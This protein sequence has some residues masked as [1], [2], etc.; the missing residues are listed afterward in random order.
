MEIFLKMKKT[1]KKR[2]ALAGAVLTLSTLSAMSAFA[3]GWNRTGDS[4]EYLDKDNIPVTSEF[5]K[6]G[7]NWF[8][9]GED[10]KMITNALVENKEN[11]YFVNE[12]GTMITNEWRKVDTDGEEK[13]R[14]YYFD[15]TGKALKNTSSSLSNSKLKTINGKKYA[16]DSEGRM[17]YGWVSKDNVTVSDD[18]MAY[19]DADYYFGVEDDGAAATGWKQITVEKDG[20][21]KNAW[22]YFDDFGRKKTGEKTINGKKYVFD[23]D[24]VMKEDWAIKAIATPS[25]TSRYYLNGDGAKRVKTWFYAVPSEE[26]NREDYEENKASWFY[27]TNS[28]D[29]EKD[30]IKKIKGKYYAFDEVGRMKTGLVLAQN[31]T[32]VTTEYLGKELNDLTAEELA[33]ANLDADLYLFGGENDGTMKTGYQKVALD[34]ETAEMYFS[35]KGTAENGYVSKIK[36]FVRNGLVLKA[37]RDDNNLVGLAGITYANGK[38]NISDFNGFVTEDNAV[39]SVLVNTS[40]VIIKNKDNVKDSNGVYY[41]TDNQGFV[42]FVSDVP[43]KKARAGQGQ[44][45]LKGIE[46][47]LAE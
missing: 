15:N 23:D 29:V 25:S 20:E 30:A 40:G 43:L 32:N 28:G 6:S 5:R 46:W 4:W 24:G 26:V 3:Q 35:N 42:L 31:K 47:K 39:G 41:M 45:T 44:Y 14:W 12:D 10:G 22:F 33:E 1:S 37:N 2:M 34:G 27:A 19:A 18:D 11:F 13:A 16:F 9:L 21:E 8:Y 36:K 17:L 38:Y 7:D